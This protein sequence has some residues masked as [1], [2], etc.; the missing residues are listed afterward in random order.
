MLSPLHRLGVSLVCGVYR[1]VG[2]ARR[3]VVI[4]E[5]SEVRYGLVG[6]GLRDAG[7]GWLSV[8]AAWHG[9]C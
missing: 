6:K 7:V 5:A 8:V 2:L 4:A 3:G 1:Q 9:R